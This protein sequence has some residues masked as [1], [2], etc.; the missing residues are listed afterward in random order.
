[1][2][3]LLK[4]RLLTTPILHLRVLRKYVSINGQRCDPLVDMFVHELTEKGLNQKS[5]NHI[6][7]CYKT[8]LQSSA[9]LSNLQEKYAGREMSV[10]DSARLVGL[11]LPQ[12]NDQPS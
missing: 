9:A 11:E 5:V 6:V 4:L 3:P 10:A 2:T 7:N 12:R 1:M 8:Y